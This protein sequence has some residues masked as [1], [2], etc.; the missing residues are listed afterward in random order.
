MSPKYRVICLYET[1]I[2]LLPTIHDLLTIVQKDSSKGVNLAT[3]DW[4]D[5]PGIVKWL[6]NPILRKL[7]KKLNV[8]TAV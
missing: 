8:T 1:L 5:V 6:P 7:F 4:I 3:N 2:L